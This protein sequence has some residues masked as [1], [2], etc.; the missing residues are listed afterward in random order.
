M[1]FFTLNLLPQ[2]VPDNE[3]PVSTGMMEGMTAR[4]GKRKY[5]SDSDVDE[6]VRSLILLLKVIC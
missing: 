5:D 1:A 3:E 6:Q 2:E 4:E